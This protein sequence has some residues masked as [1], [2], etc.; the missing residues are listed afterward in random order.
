MPVSG[1]RPLLSGRSMMYT[2]VFS[3]N[4]P[5]MRIQLVLLLSAFCNLV[6]ANTVS[7]VVKEV[8][9]YRSGAK[10]TSVAKVSVPAGR[11]EVVFENLSAYF[12]SQSLQVKLSGGATLNSAVFQMKYPGPAPELPRA[13]V[14]R[15]SIVIL[16]DAIVTLRDEADV[17]QKESA[18]ITKNADQVGTF[19]NGQ[20]NSKLTVTELRELAEYYSRR[21][22]EIKKLLQ[23]LTIDERRINQRIQT[24][25]QELQGLY[26]NTGN[27]TGEIV[28][29]IQSATAQSIEI[30]CTYLVQNAHWAPLYD[31]RSSGL[32][33]PLKLVYKGDVYNNTGFDWKDVKVTLSSATPLVNN[34]RPILNPIFVDYR[35]V[36]Y[37]QER[38]KS[39]DQLVAPE[40][41]ANS[42]QLMD[43]ARSASPS[44]DGGGVTIRGGR[45]NGSGFFVDGVRVYG[46]GEGP[47]DGGF[48]APTEEFLTTFEIA[49]NQDIASDGKPNTLTVE[50][51]DMAAVY[52]YHAVPKL[53]AAVFLLA[54]VPDYGK[55]NLLPGT[56]NIFFKETFVGQ[57]TVNPNVTS[58]TL[59][60]S[61]GRDEQVT[62]KRVQ[63]KDFTERKKIL[64]N[65]V[66][67]TYAFEITVKNNKNVPINIEVLDQFPV[68]KQENIVVELLEKDGAQ[69]SET[70]GK[71]IWKLD[72]KP[73]QN[74]K[75]MFSYSIKYPKDQT[76]GL[77]K[78]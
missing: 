33:Q 1:K 22:L 67:E 65:T 36:A 45:D 2:S 68:S 19:P 3:P 51:K 39:K 62:I 50:E 16:N 15:D 17:Y 35:P 21:L 73:G 8:T 56:A 64:S 59:L 5:D 30:S 46:P 48:E 7:P 66:K 47:A 28:M 72:I 71:L 43:A 18:L 63:P 10:L 60:L 11:S 6:T 78:F 69:V 77:M 40:A 76:I 41:L 57:T 49:E 44:V 54:K 4:I 27:A 61:L 12:N 74:K 9:V 23:R 37:Y 55:Y 53:D 58:D 75:V 32:D 29:K 42:Y 38:A 20:P 25:S 52:Q 13:R 70:Y 31:L 14:I 24:I 26:P 34:N